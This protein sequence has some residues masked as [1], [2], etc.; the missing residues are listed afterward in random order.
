DQAEGSLAQARSQAAAAATAPEQIAL[1]E[2]RAATADAQVQQA[3]AAVGL[4]RLNLDRTTVRAATGGLVSRKT[5]EM[6]QVV[7]PGQPLLAITTAGDVWI[8]ANF[9]ETQLRSMRPGQRADVTVDAAGGRKYTGHVD[10]LAAATGATFSMLPPDN[11]SGNFV[12][13]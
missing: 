5:V 6:G 8:T 9:K 12:K 13:V 10:S 7:Q 2:A 1:S 3:E 11:A 4:A